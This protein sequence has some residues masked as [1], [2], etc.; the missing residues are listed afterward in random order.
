MSYKN[1]QW[2]CFSGSGAPMQQIHELNKTVDNE[3]KNQ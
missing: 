2:W 3:K 1:N